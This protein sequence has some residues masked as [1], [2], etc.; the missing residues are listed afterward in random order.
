MKMLFSMICQHNPLSFPKSGPRYWPFVRGIHLSPVNSLHKCQ[1]RGAL[2]FSLIFAWIHGWVNNRD[3]GD[4][5]SNRAH[6]DVTV[7][8]WQGCSTP[9][10]LCTGLCTFYFFSWSS[11]LRNPHQFCSSN[12][13][14]IQHQSLYASDMNTITVFC[15]LGLQFKWNQNGSN[16]SRHTSCCRSCVPS[17]PMN[18]PLRQWCWVEFHPASNM[19]STESDDSWHA[20]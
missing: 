6:Y 9:S 4:S 11:L 12:V 2:M 18:S 10:S 1:W 14:V 7:M 3:A 8:K 19:R 15:V 17:K 20:S 5:R 16:S 13:W